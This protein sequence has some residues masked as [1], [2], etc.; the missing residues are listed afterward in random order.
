MANL[1]VA[2]EALD[3][4][5]I[6]FYPANT[7]AA[8]ESKDTASFFTGSSLAATESLDQALFTVESVP[9]NLIAVEKADTVLI[10]ILEGAVIEVAAVEAKDTASVNGYNGILVEFS[11][12]EKPDRASFRE[13]SGT[14]ISILAVESPDTALVAVSTESSLIIAGTEDTDF[15]SFYLA[16]VPITFIRRAIVM[17]LFSHAV[18]HYVNFNFNSLA[19]FNGLFLGANEEGIFPLGGDNDLGVEIQAY[20]RSGVHDLAD[21]GIVKLP[22]EA[23]MAYRSNGQMELGIEVDEDKNPY[24]YVFDKSATKIT[25]ARKPLA[26]GVT[27]RF[28][29]FMIKNKEGSNFDLQSLRILGDKI[30]RKRR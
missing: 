17:H 11:V 22:K 3:I 30:S 2:I 25:E 10:D 15:G 8:V 9:I 4:G 5:A 18:S 16:E 29:T 7:L 23:W 21:D 19:H 20:I 12:T 1:L 24:R 27:Q 28:Y 26:K 13:L 14:I 6:E